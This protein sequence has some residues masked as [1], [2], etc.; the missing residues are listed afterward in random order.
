MSEPAFE[1]RLPAFLVHSETYAL[2]IIDMA[3]NYA[4]L[5][6]LCQSWYGFMKADMR[7]EPVS[8]TIHPED[9]QA[10]ID[11]SY[12][13]LST[14]GKSFNV[15]MRKPVKEPGIYH[16]T[17]WEFSSYHAEDGGFMGILAI[18]HDIDNER[19]A[20][21]QLQSSEDRYS[22]IISTMQE[23]ILIRD[24]EGTIISCNK[25]AETILDI[26]YERM[27][28]R[29]TVDDQWL[30]I[31]EDGSLILGDE[32]PAA[33]TLKH[34]IPVNN[35]VLGVVKPNQATTWISIS[36]QLLYHPGNPEPFAVYSIFHDITSLKQAEEKA[37][38][39][40]HR[41]ED[42]ISGTNIGT[43]EWDI[44]TG[45]LIVN[46]RWAEII[47][48]T[49]E[50]LEPI[51][52]D[53]WNNLTHPADLALAN[54]MIAEHI[55][56]KIP[57][58]DLECRMRHKK[59]HWVWVLDRGKISHWGPDGKA[60]IMSGTH[61]DITARK[62]AEDRIMEQNEKLRQIAYDQSHVL[63]KPIASMLGLC[64]VIKQEME[65]NDLRSMSQYLAFLRQT[66]QEADEVIHTI[67]GKTNE[68][69]K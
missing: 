23:G 49:P 12:K 58:Y 21:L 15:A 60:L 42:I 63:R 34:Q 40:S 45:G 7:G 56:G 28:G 6:P 20:A 66:A 3:G 1:S 24:M 41:L 33:Y 51:N 69:E 43:W 54:R 38:A 52:I 68:T 25:S 13:C 44:Q 18:G 19:N 50:E 37:V 47:G 17:S 31:R 61:Q 8:V 14:P 48:Y 22:S 9:L 26:S 27:I 35:F 53:T 46:T 36:T 39:W 55:Q 5:N 16:W 2:A 59:G 32:H 30:S 64:D 4:Y 65:K 11:A 29:K 10:C 62:Y 57:F 67:V